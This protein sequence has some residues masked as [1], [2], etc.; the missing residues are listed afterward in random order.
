MCGL[1]KVICSFWGLFVQAPGR[2]TVTL[3][4]KSP[5]TQQQLRSRTGINSP[6][7]QLNCKLK[8]LWLIIKHSLSNHSL[9]TG[10]MKNVHNFLSNFKYWVLRALLILKVPRKKKTI[11]SK[12][13][14]ISWQARLNT[15]TS[16]SKLK[17][18]SLSR[19]TTNCSGALTSMVTLAWPHAKVL[20]FISMHV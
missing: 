14:S 2:V 8:L 18:W 1:C 12:I 11:K 20:M 5:K 19:S 15:T 3:S 6:P 10:C 17:L 9:K 16:M 7:I 4:P 13:N